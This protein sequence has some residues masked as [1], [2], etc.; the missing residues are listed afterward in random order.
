MKIRAIL[1]ALICLAL[2]GIA[3]A[4]VSVNVNGTPYACQPIG[5]TAAPSATPTPSIIVGPAP[6]P[7][8]MVAFNSNPP[9]LVVS[10]VAATLSV[11]VSNSLPGGTGVGA[12]CVSID[13]GACIPSVFNPKYTMTFSLE[14]TSGYFQW[15]PMTVGAHIFTFTFYDYKGNVLATVPEQIMVAP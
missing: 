12:I 2:S 3:S 8:W 15:S 13:G 9:T 6:I 10:P 7:P 11:V 4:Q 5:P 1:A 14:A